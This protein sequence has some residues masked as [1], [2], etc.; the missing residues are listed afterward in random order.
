MS[1]EVPHDERDRAEEGRDAPALPVNLSVGCADLPPGLR[2]ERYFQRLSYLEVSVTRYQAPKLRVLEQWKAEAGTGRFGLLA[3]QEITDRPG[4]KGFFRD[5]TPRSPEQL[6]Q[7]G[8]LRKTPVVEAAVQSLAEA[9]AALAAE[10]VVFRTPADFSPS[11]T[12][13][14][15]LRA[16]FGEIAPKERFGE[17]VRVWE[18]QGLWEP[19]AAARLAAELDVALACDPLSNDPL[20]QLEV[21][22]A[23]LAAPMVYFRI[24]GLG[25]GQQRFDDY[26]L[27]PL[28]DLVPAYERTWV[29]FAHEYKYPDAIRCRRLLASLADE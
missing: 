9:C 6:A 25:R 4:P 13:R 3:P 2:R 10:T 1:D 23:G 12:N 21:D 15:R 11:A 20:H 28:L 24:T 29:V 8:G 7:A 5:P 18:P 27:E 17:A 19:P 26:A 16:F 22:F 14:D